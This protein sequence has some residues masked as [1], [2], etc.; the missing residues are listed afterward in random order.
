MSPAVARTSNTP[1]SMDSNDTSKVPNVVIAI[2]LYPLLLT[3]SCKF[4]LYLISSTICWK[5]WHSWIFFHGHRLPTDG[6]R[7]LDLVSEPSSSFVGCL[8]ADCPILFFFTVPQLI[9]VCP[10]LHYWAWLVEKALRGFP[11]IHQVFL[12]LEANISNL[13]DQK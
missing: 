13:Q 1:S 2:A 3:L 6:C 11:S 10:K 9:T 8:A 4:G 12:Y 5:S 7:I